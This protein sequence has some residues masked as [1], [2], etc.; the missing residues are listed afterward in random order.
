MADLKSMAESRSALLHY[1]PR[2]LK[3]KPGLNARDLET[4]ENW[5]HVEFL[6]QSIA[7]NGFLPSHPLEIFAEGDAVYV[8][9]G[10]CRLTATMLAIARGVDIKT[11]ACVP[12][13]RGTN[14]VDR[15]LNQNLANSGKRLTP[16]EEGHNIKRAMAL[17]ATIAEVAGK[18]GKSQTY[19]AQS[20]DFQAAP[21]AVHAMVRK[22]EVSA[23]LAAKTLRRHGHAGVAT[24]QK[25]V[26]S[27]KAKG[28]AK[29]TEKDVD[30][31]AEAD[32]NARA[33]PA[34]AVRIRRHAA[35]LLG[36]TIG[37]T[38]FVLS[39]DYWRRLMQRISI[40]LLT[41]SSVPVLAPP[42]GV[43]APE[44]ADEAVS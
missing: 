38:E 6:A 5:E 35:K 12:E 23:T 39:D 8:S 33:N 9:D 28:K 2:T 10:H 44:T 4:P 36:V 41:Y 27:A 11:V 29:A 14:E 16:L 42:T 13:R 15:L 37:R 43:A 21:A 19:V 22:G 1:D 40:A 24:I 30:K 34:D 32:H 31:Q 26:D 3:L 18:L 20:L 25:A 17:G 7:A